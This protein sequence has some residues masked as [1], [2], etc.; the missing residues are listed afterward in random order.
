MNK[1]VLKEDIKDLQFLISK[2]I[3]EKKYD[4]ASECKKEIERIK[5]ELRGK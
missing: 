1:E 3:K 2:Y 5:E 4:K